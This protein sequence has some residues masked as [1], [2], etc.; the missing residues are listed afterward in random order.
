MLYTNNG[1]NFS[2]LLYLHC[3]GFHKP[4]NTLK[5]IIHQTPPIV[6]PSHYGPPEH[7]QNSDTVFCTGQERKSTVK[8]RNAST[9][10]QIRSNKHTE[11]NRVSINMTKANSK[12]SGGFLLIF[13]GKNTVH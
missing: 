5:Y 8:I 2:I 7:P 3:T 4:S 13:S 1:W 10:V 9:M 11:L 6:Q 12:P